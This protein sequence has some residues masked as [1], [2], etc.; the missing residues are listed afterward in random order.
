MTFPQVLTLVLLFASTVLLQGLTVVAATSPEAE[1]DPMP[2]F[3][4]AIAVIAIG[5]AILL[6]HRKQKQYSRENPSQN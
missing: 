1:A 2:G 6:A 5:I 3:G 4:F